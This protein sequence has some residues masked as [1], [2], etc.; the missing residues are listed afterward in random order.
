[1]SFGWTGP[2]HPYHCGSLAHARLPSNNPGGETL[3]TNRVAWGGESGE[4]R[5]GRRRP[6]ENFCEIIK[7]HN[8][9][10]K[11]PPSSPVATDHAQTRNDQKAANPPGN[12]TTVHYSVMIQKNRCP[13]DDTPRKGAK[14]RFDRTP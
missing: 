3:D 2:P 14:R 9:G 4:R 5:G 10:D 7:Q 12:E 6:G 1:V 11:K 13:P 8:L